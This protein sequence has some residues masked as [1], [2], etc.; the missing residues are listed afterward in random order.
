MNFSPQ[1]GF[2]AQKFQEKQQNNR[3][4]KSDLEQ[5]L[6]NAN[7]SQSDIQSLIQQ[8]NEDEITYNQFLSI[9]GV[10]DNSQNVQTYQQNNGYEIV[11]EQQQKLTSEQLQSIYDDYKIALKNQDFEKTKSIL[12]QYRDIDLVNKIDPSQ[13]QISTYIAVQGPDDNVALQT[14]ELLF[15]FGANLNYKDQLGQS[16]LFYI[17]RDGRLKLLDFVLSTNTVNV[18]D[19]D[20]YGQTPLFYAARDNRYDI[21]IRLIQYGIDINIVDKL[22]SQT[23]LFYAANGGHVDICK[24][25]IENGSNPGHVDSS[26]KNALFFARKY[27]RKEVIDLFNNYFNKNKDDMSKNSGGNDNSKGEAPRSQQQKKKFNNLPK[28]SYKLIFTDNQGNQRELNSVEFIKFQQEYPEVANL[29]VN[30]DE[31]IDDT[32]INQ[33]KDDDTWEKI[34]KKVLGI[35][36][37]AKG[38]HLFHQPVDQKKYGISDYYEIVTKPMDFGTIKNKLNSNV[39]TSCQEFYD[40]VMQVFENC[41]LYN[42]ETSEVGQIGLNIRQ[43]FQSQLELTLLKKYL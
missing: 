12:N 10:S 13:R 14:L 28:Q 33:I 34:A 21:V 38:A 23:A 30:A 31:L 7:Y 29:I 22:S 5:I 6:E 41:I 19:Q 26:K 37:K 2:L 4:T 17:C 3:I 39:Y 18:N 9:V 42:G 32:I 20:R 27:N 15:D 35:I 24:V 11:S 8:I 40:D 25:L 1:L 36:W 16:I 43:E